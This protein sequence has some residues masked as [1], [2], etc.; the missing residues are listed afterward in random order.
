MND[1]TIGPTDLLEST[2][3]AVS[4]DGKQ[5]ILSHRED[6]EPVLYSAICPH[7]HGR[8]KVADGSTFRCPNH[9]WEFDATSGECIRG[10]NTALDAYD[11]WVASG[12]LRTSL[13]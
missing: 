6:G 10:G 3:T 11:V 2:P 9:R 7:Q 1:T 13:E 12:E 8:V 5:Y 4:I